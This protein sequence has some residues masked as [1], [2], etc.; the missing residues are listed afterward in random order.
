M[1]SGG[2]NLNKHLPCVILSATGLQTR[3]R[4]PQKIHPR[5]V[6]SWTE[7]HFETGTAYSNNLV[8]IREAKNINRLDNEC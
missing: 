8:P 5:L 3:R 4:V 2:A 6:R 7:Q 1:S